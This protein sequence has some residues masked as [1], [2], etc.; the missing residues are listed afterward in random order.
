MISHF[1]TTPLRQTRIPIVILRTEVLIALF[2]EFE[3]PAQFML[4]RYGQ[5]GGGSKNMP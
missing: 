2:S 4:N 3:H 5:R 1:G